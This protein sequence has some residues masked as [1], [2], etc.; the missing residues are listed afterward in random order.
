MAPD[1][2]DI[3][4]HSRHKKAKYFV[5]KKFIRTLKTKIYKCITS[6]SRNMNIGKLAD[7]VNK[8]IN[9][10]H[11]TVKVKSVD[12]KPSIFIAFTIETNDEDP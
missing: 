7:R 2:D 9:T 11:R 6:I 1:D 12:V 3:E 4:M 10:Y 5:A 8:Y